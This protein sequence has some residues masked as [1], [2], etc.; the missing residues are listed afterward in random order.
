MIW[1]IKPYDFRSR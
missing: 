1:Q